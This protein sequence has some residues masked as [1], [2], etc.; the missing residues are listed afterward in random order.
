MKKIALLCGLVSI[1]Y[2]PL[3][4][5]AGDETIYYADAWCSVTYTGGHCT[6]GSCDSGPDTGIGFGATEEAAKEAARINCTEHSTASAKQQGGN[7]ITV[8]NPYNDYAYLGRNTKIPSV[9]KGVAGQWICAKQQLK[10]K[11]ANSEDE[12][13]AE[14]ANPAHISSNNP[15]IICLQGKSN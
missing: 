6:N 9:T 8:T 1:L 2:I 3:Q 12:A 10:A 15:E 7:N 14:L 5:Q 11:I 13:R 4:A